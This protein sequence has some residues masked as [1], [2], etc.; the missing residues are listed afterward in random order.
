MSLLAVIVEAKE[1]FH[2]RQTADGK[3][4]AFFTDGLVIRTI[5]LSPCVLSLGICERVH[6]LIDVYLSLTTYTLVGNVI[7]QH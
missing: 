1:S 6:T 5:C 2:W 3:G 4:M 7:L